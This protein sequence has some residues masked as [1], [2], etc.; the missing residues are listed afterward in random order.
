MK[1]KRGD[2]AVIFESV[3]Y[4]LGVVSSVTRD[5]QVK[6]VDRI[7]INPMWEGDK[8][9]PKWWCRERDSFKHGVYIG[10]ADQLVTDPA[11]IIKKLGRDEFDSLEAARKAV[12]PWLRTD[13]V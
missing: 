13:L 3:R 1:A 4:C 2:L 7:V 12:L 8:I 6:A 11:S 9:M 5:G 10:K